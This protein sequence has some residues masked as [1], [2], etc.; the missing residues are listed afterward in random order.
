MEKRK[1]GQI[2]AAAE[3][4]LKKVEEIVFPEGI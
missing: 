2:R 4:L 1:K 3:S